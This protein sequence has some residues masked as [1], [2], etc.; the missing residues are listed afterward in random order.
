MPD[1][2]LL[3]PFR[4]WV[5]ALGAREWYRKGVEVAALDG[6]IHPHYGVFPPTR[7][8]Y[9]ELF[10]QQA[11]RTCLAGKTASDIGTGTGVLAL[12]L[13]RRGAA[14][15]VAT[16]AQMRAVACTGKCHAAGVRA[17]GRSP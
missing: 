10:A 1:R 2:P 16:N 15:V 12:I 6:R 14:R 7:G 4:E 8:D 11:S 9:L 13:A 3:V 5:G 17:C